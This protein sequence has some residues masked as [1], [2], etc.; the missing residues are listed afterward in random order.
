MMKPKSID[1]HNNR[2]L[3]ALDMS[4]ATE[5]QTRAWLR[6]IID[7][8]LSRGDAADEALI[9]ECMEQME[10]LAGD[11]AMSAEECRA[12]LSAF[13]DTVSKPTAPAPTFRIAS[14]RPWS[15]WCIAAAM[16]IMILLCTPTIHAYAQV[17]SDNKLYHEAIDRAAPDTPTVTVPEETVYNDMAS[18]IRDHG[19]LDFFYPH[20]LKEGEE[21]RSIRMT[22]QSAQSWIA[23]F[24][25]S[26]PDI[27]HFTVQRLSQPSHMIEQPQGEKIFP[28]G[29]QNYVLSQSEK[30]G[31]T[32][33]HA[34]CITDGIRYTVEASSSNTLRY[35]LAMTFRAYDTFDD[36]QDLLQ[37]HDYLQPFRYPANLSI[38]GHVSYG[39]SLDWAV[40][41]SFHT[42][43]VGPTESITVYPVRKSTVFDPGD[44]PIILSNENVDIYLLSQPTS[45]SNYLKTA[46]V[47]DGMLYK[48]NI[49][50]YDQ[51]LTIAESMFGPF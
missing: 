44:A 40:Y 38:Q 13:W 21:L 28:T 33:Y 18:F 24:H 34:E 39:G 31:V 5:E 48:M 29:T 20:F 16:L 23:I 47:A 7:N 41:M 51:L 30:D 12:H 25:F 45:K 43:T 26:N 37:T 11:A 2:E 10:Q 22:Y 17:Y 4:H 15:R 6:Q 14:R 36:I 27:R 8:E 9:L 50:G 42:K 49:N 46:C 35:Y 1:I 3:C 19:D 32:L